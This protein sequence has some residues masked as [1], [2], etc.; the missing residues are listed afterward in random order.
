[1]CAEK[2]TFSIAAGQT[3]LSVVWKMGGS[4]WFGNS[5]EEND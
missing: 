5:A 2:R 4:F 3:L 1:M